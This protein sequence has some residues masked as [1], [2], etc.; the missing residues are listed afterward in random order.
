MGKAVI[1]EKKTRIRLQ[2]T[3]IRSCIESDHVTVKM[4]I[5]GMVEVVGSVIILNQRESN[6]KI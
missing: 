2:K 1:E 6:G 3:L 5:D 4:L